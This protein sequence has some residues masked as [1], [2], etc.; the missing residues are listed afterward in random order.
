MLANFSANSARLMA[1]SER[2]AALSFRCER[3]DLN[4]RGTWQANVRAEGADFF[5]EYSQG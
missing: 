5:G 4:E 2:A 3:G 1:L